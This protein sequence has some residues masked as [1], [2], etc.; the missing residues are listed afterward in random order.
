MKKINFIKRAKSWIFRALG[1][2]SSYNLRFNSALENDGW[3]ISWSKK[4]AYNSNEE[5]IPWITY[6][7]HEYIKKNLPPSISVFEYGSGNGTLWWASVAK[8]VISCEHDK[9]WFQKMSVAIPQNAKIIFAELDID[10]TYSKVILR[11]KNKFDIVV[12]D[13]R[14][15]VACAINCLPSLTDEG[16]LIF[17]DS[18]RDYYADAFNFLHQ[19]GFRRVDFIGM[20]PGLLLKCQTSIFYR[21]NN[22]FNL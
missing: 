7:S 22:I 6:P 21:D 3:F 8:E 9:E 5:P 15:R 2:E 18:D 14:E 12:I 4:G 19:K 10:G 16:V 17:D 1:I 13:G 20:A 11:Y